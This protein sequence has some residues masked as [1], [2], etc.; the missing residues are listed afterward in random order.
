MS[1]KGGSG[2]YDR[3]GSSGVYPVWTQGQRR[4]DWADKRDRMRDQ[5][6]GWSDEQRLKNLAWVINNNRYL[7]FLPW[8]ALK[9]GYGYEIYPATC[10][11]GL[12]ARLQKTGRIVGA[13]DRF[14][15]KNQLALNTGY[16]WV[17]LKMTLDLQKAG[18]FWSPQAQLRQIPQPDGFEC[19][20]GIH[21]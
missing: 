8:S 21:G 15:V 13:I 9:P 20:Q 17:N 10:W 6:I 3:E 16:A 19:L 12:P 1:L 14:L 18:R 5:W 11:G 2:S 7:I 4:G